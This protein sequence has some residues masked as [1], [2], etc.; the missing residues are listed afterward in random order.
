VTTPTVREIRQ[1]LQARR[2]DLAKLGVASL[3]VFGSVARNEATSDSDVDILV[4]F[5]QAATLAGYMDLKA[6][7]EEALGRRV[8]L[9]TRKSL[10]DRLRPVVERDAVRVA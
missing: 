4:E 6:L 1:A 3:S 5:D 7:L 2:A 9:V 10:R 8:D